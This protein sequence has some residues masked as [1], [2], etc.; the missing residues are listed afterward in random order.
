MGN[1]GLNVWHSPIRKD[2]LVE[3]EL[4]DMECHP[5]ELNNLWDCLE[6]RETRQALTERLLERS[7]AQELRHGSRGGET[8][9]T[10]RMGNLLK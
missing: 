7:I 4:H 2:P 10:Q 3:G 8:P 6:H 1:L 5:L 9:P